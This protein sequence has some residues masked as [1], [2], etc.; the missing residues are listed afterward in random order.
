MSLLTTLLT[1]ETTTGGGGGGGTVTAVSGTSSITINGTPGGSSSS[2]AQIGLANTLT[3]PTSDLTLETLNNHNVILAPNGN[4]LVSVLSASVLQSVSAAGLVVGSGITNTSN[5]AGSGAAQIISTTAASNG[6]ATT[7]W[8]SGSVFYTAGI[9]G[10]DNIFKMS[11]AYPIGTNN[12]LTIDQSTGLTSLFNNFWV[13]ADIAATEVSSKVSNIDVTDVTSHATFVVA[14]GGATGGN[15]TTRYTIAGVTSWTTGIDNADGDKYKISASGLVDVSPL[16]VIDSA[17]IID[18]NVKTINQQLAAVGAPV[19]YIMRN[20]DNTNSASHTVFEIASGGLAGGNAFTYLEALGGSSYSYGIN[21]ASGNFSLNTGYNV[22]VGNQFLEYVSSTGALAISTLNSAGVAGD[23]SITSG[24]SSGTDQSGAALAIT[25]GS[26]NGAGSGGIFTLISGAS[27]VTGSG[28]LQY[29]QTGDG[30][31]A[32]GAGGDWQVQTGNALANND[33]GGDYIISLGAGN[34]T[35]RSG[36]ARF[37]GGLLSRRFVTPSV[38][39]SGSPLVLAA[40]DSATVFTNTGTSAKSYF[41]LPAAVLGY[42]Y[43]FVTTDAD[44]IRVVCN[45]TDTVRLAGAVSGAGGY[46][47]STTIG[48]SIT[49]TCVAAGS[50]YAVNHVGTGSVT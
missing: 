5:A 19:T 41:T 22:G 4:G 13:N 8:A 33:H 31:S 6:N 1:P 46:Y 18:L 25:T 43:T 35:G 50:W 10:S 38:V 7:S 28:A 48:D 23:L 17:G 11:A 30:G 44:G 14:T 16:V 26:G 32:G 9:D 15:P 29:F 2:T 21:S 47:E 42:T 37:E 45:G 20:S 34:G 27:G 49:L 36:I 3:A 12:L 39:G 24:S 40:N